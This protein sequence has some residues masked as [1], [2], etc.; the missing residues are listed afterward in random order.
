MDKIPIEFEYEGQS[1]SG[2]FTIANGMGSSAILQ[3][4]ID[5]FYKGQLNFT[6]H[7]SWQWSSNKDYFKGMDE[8][9]GS[10]AIAWL[11]GQ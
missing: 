3:L 8:Y 6:E 10:Y 4:Y 1:Y 11:D 7:F 2:N 5:H 9:F